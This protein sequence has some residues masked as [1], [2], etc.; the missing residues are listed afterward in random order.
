M[1]A[2]VVTG[3]SIASPIIAGL[4]LVALASELMRG[5]IIKLDSRTVLQ[6]AVRRDTYPKSPDSGTIQLKRTITY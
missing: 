6:N 3:C 2:R 4:P 5:P 1:F